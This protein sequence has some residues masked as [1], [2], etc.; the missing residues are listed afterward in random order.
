MLRYISVLILL[1]GLFNLSLSQTKEFSPLQGKL[2]L[3]I[4][5]AVLFP[6]TDFI[7][8]VQTPLGVG[9]IDY[10]FGIKSKHVLGIHFYG[11][12]GELAGTDSNL[13]PYEYSDN[14][15]F[16]GGGLNYGYTIGHTF[17]PYVFFGISNL[18]FNPMDNNNN[19]IIQNKPVSENLTKVT[20]NYEIG[21]KIILSERTTMNFS[22]GI[23]ATMTD[24]LDGLS[25]GNYNDAFY[26]GMVGISVSFSG[27]E[28]SDDDGIP[29]SFDA[30]PDTPPG[31]K[32]N[33]HGCP[34][35]ADNDGIPDYKD[36]CA[37]TPRGTPVDSNGCSVLPDYSQ[38]EKYNSQNEYAASKMVYTDGRI[39]VIQISAWR[40]RREAEAEAEKFRKLGYNAFVDDNLKDKWNATWYRVRIGYFDTFFEAQT[41]AEKLK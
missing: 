40:T 11:G 26:Y 22:G 7:N 9:S 24:Y 29:D 17:I 38:I 28:D 23:F 1:A 15:F 5:G 20:Y 30:C 32:V 27:D 6:R 2:F 8:P 19:P 31:I 37:D 39:Y 41:L 12:M 33:S 10:Y 21:L 13:T 35:D 34:P 18:W 4:S 14:L 16:F 25:I 36:K 3:S